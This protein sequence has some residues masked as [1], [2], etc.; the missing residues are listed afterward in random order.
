MFEAVFKCNKSSTRLKSRLL[1]LFP[2]WLVLEKC[3]VRFDVSMKLETYQMEVMAKEF[4][5]AVETV[6][7]RRC[8]NNVIL[9]PGRDVPQQRYWVFHLALT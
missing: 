3:S 7:E 9:R 2:S 5:N 4:G 6:V 1:L 8:H